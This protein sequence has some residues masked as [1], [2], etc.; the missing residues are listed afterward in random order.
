MEILKR[1]LAMFSFPFQVSCESGED[2][3][4]LVT[5]GS[6]ICFSESDHVANIDNRSNGTLT[7]QIAKAS[8]GEVLRAQAA[9]GQ[10]VFVGGLYHFMSKAPIPFAASWDR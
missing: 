5:F 2:A 1:S 9:V 3:A 7:D 10:E 6:A 8:V 4:V